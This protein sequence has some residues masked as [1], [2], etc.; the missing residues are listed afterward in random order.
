MLHLNALVTL[1]SAFIIYLAN[2]N[3]HMQNVQFRWSRGGT[4]CEKST[5]RLFGSME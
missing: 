2:E 3:V 4:M 5:M 1:N